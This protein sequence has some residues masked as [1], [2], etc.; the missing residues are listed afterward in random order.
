MNKK[1]PPFTEK[2]DRGGDPASVMGSLI[3][4]VVL[5]VIAALIFFSIFGGPAQ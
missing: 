2:V 4:G 5:A 3:S 1:I